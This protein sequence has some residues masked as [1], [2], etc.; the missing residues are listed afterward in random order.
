MAQIPAYRKLGIQGFSVPST[1]FAGLKEQAG[2]FNDLNQKIGAV[3]SYAND[4]ISAEQKIK[5]QEYAV[6]NPITLDQYFN[7]NPSEI[8]KQIEARG[9][10]DRTVKG[11]AIKATLIELLSTD[12]LL[13]A[14]SHLGKIYDDA[15][16]NNVTLE[17]F[18][19]KLNS[20]IDGY[21][22]S[23]I[24]VSPEAGLKVKAD[25]GI[26]GNTYYRNYSNKLLDEA[27]VAKQAGILSGSYEEIKYIPE[28]IR[29]GDLEVQLDDGST[30]TFNIDTQLDSYKLKIVNNMIANQFNETQVKAFQSSWDTAVI[31][32]KQN[33]LEDIQRD[34]YP[35][36][37]GMDF[38]YLVQEEFL[39]INDMEDGPAKQ[40]LLQAKYIFD[41]LE[42]KETIYKNIMNQINAHQTRVGIIE[43]EIDK[44]EADIL[45]KKTLEFSIAVVNGDMNK[46]EEVI[47]FLAK[48]PVYADTVDT[49]L[50]AIQSVDAVGFDTPN[51]ES[52]IRQKITVGSVN[53][54]DIYAYTDENNPEGTLKLSTANKLVEEAKASNTKNIKKAMLIVKATIKNMPQDVQDSKNWSTENRIAMQL[55][56]RIHQSLLLEQMQYE[57]NILEDGEAENP[58]RPKEFVLSMIEEEKKILKDTGI[59]ETITSITNQF[60]GTIGQEDMMVNL[61]GPNITLVPITKDITSKQID[62]WIEVIDFDLSA[63]KDK[64]RVLFTEDNGYKNWSKVKNIIGFMKSNLETLKAQLA[65]LE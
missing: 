9:G 4:Q 16:L 47:E 57:D 59:K 6:G 17:E 55:Y 26:K 12:L 1:S 2:M 45:N 52:K 7:A 23:I 36:E 51:L 31:K 63:T 35:D 61:G 56:E 14:N 44:A 25:L 22:Q 58:F 46:A 24:T 18:E 37:K 53:V 40:Q 41:S 62:Q 43:G 64:Y 15:V 50:K 65:Q 28:I 30:A 8:A 27:L 60:N 21:Y 38:L 49:L 42:D 20:A 13:E 54:F 33:F 39:G 34:F 11:Q 10:D 32:G 5:G 19:N 3:V 29:A 48:N